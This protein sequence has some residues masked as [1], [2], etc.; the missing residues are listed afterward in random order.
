MHED[1]DSTAARI[2][3]PEEVAGTTLDVVLM[4]LRIRSVAL[5]TI[6]YEISPSR[7]PLN[8]ALPPQM[9]L[10]VHWQPAKRVRVTT[11]F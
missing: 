4:G 3:G 6:G 5:L 10:A 2:P 7:A 1:E 11:G 8:L 9:S